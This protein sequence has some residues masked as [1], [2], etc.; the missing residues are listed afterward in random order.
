MSGPDWIEPSGDSAETLLL[1]ALAECQAMRAD[2]LEPQLVILIVNQDGCP[3][4]RRARMMIGELSA[5]AVMLSYR[6]QCDLDAMLAPPV[7]YAEAE[8]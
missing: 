2:G 1:G 7:Y 4:I 3:G 5:C 6:A 8:E